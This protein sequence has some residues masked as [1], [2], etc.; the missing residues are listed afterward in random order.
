MV[1]KLLA[2]ATLLPL[3]FA[4]A[5][6]AQARDYSLSPDQLSLVDQT[7]LQVMGLKRGETQFAG[8]RESL[9]QALA[10]KSESQPVAAAYASG[11]TEAGKSFYAVPPSVRWN[12]ERY[13]CARLGLLP[14]STPFGQCVAGLEDAFMPS[15]N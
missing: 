15:P 13:S 10:A 2:T 9:S 3:V 8:C 5:P 14:G 4:C 11:D 6:F 12:R 7:C 1:R